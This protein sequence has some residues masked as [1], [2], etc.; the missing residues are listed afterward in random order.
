MSLPEYISMEGPALPAGATV[1]GA[2]S[3]GDDE[4]VPELRSMSGGWLRE[5]LGRVACED[6]FLRLFLAPG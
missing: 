3:K 1:S 5:A 4:A 2:A 6:Q